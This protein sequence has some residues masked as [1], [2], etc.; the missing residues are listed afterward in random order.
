LVSLK[1]EIASFALFA[2]KAAPTVVAWMKRSVIRV[3][4][5]KVTPDSAVL[6]PGYD[7]GKGFEIMLC[8][9]GTENTEVLAANNANNAKV[10]TI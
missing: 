5:R 1:P 6:H 8:H 7:T 3:V 10:K 2:A 9:R 4:Q